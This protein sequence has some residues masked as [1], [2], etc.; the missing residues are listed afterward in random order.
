MLN[1]ITKRLFCQTRVVRSFFFGSK[2]EDSYKELKYHYELIMSF[3]EL[4]KHAKGSKD[5]ELIITS[6]YVY[7]QRRSNNPSIVG[8]L[9]SLEDLL[10]N[11][12]KLW[13]LVEGRIE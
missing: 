4:T 8:M 11:Q 9:T 13:L 1:R 2:K 10:W 6:V 12:H 5:I 3:F 7:H